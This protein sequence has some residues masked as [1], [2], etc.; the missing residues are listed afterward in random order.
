MG[1]FPNASKTH[2][3]IKP[4]LMDEATKIFTN[5][6]T[7]ITTQGQRHLGAAIGTTSFAETCDAQ[8]GKMDS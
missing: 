5:T 4:E 7:Q 6:S 1:Y 8:S 2:L 3:V